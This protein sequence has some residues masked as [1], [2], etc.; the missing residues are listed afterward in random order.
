MLEKDIHNILDIQESIEKIFKYTENID[1]FE[2]FES[3]QLVTDAVLMNIVAIGES[4]ARISE[5]FKNLNNDIEWNKI[6]GLRNI[7]A[8]NYFGIDIE[9]IWQIVKTEIPELN[10]Q[11][12]FIIKNYV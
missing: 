10:Q 8:H 1:K 9:E 12:D 2:E 3:N 4:V 7:I 11:I 5:D 6:K